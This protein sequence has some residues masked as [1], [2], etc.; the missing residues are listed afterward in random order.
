MAKEKTEATQ[1]PA[2]TQEPVYDA[3]EIAQNSK[4]LFGYGVDLAKAAL[5]FNNVNA[6][7][8]EE[9]KRIIKEFAERKVN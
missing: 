5:D 1:T 6:C 2:T 8:L 3:A 4:R 7:T 9:A